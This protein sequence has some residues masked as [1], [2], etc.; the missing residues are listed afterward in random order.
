MAVSLD[1]PAVMKITGISVDRADLDEKLQP[2]G[3]GKLDVE[4]DHVG[5]ERRRRASTASRPVETA[6]TVKSAE[7]NARRNTSRIA[8]SS[9]TTRRTG[10][11]VTGCGEGCAG[12]VGSG[13]ATGAMYHGVAHRLTRVVKRCTRVPSMPHDDPSDVA[14]NFETVSRQDDTPIIVGRSGQF[15]VWARLMLL[16]ETWPKRAD[17]GSKVF[18]TRTRTHPMTS[19]FR[20]LFAAPRRTAKAVRRGER[21]TH[22]PDARSH[23]EAELKTGNWCPRTSSTS[24]GRAKTARCV[25]GRYGLF[26]DYTHSV[27]ATVNYNT[28]WTFNDPSD[29]T[30][31]VDLSVNNVSIGHVSVPAYYPKA[32][33]TVKA[34]YFVG[35]AGNDTFDASNLSVPVSGNAG[36]GDDKMYGGSGNDYFLGGDG[37]DVIYGN[38]GNDVLI[39][40]LGSD[41]IHGNVGNDT[42][43]GGPPAHKAAIRT[44]TTSSATPATTRSTLTPAGP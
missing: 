28:K 18:K 32:N 23:A 44:P 36:V 26:T 29:D 9:S 12:R 27:Q 38:G 35:T 41:V 1:P 39:G 7:E 31:E 33:A 13:T 25:S 22:H 2:R 6:W 30:F 37:N 8:G 17:R 19:L 20:K 24:T 3:V 14:D 10:M 5:P 42:V 16:H 40:E 43:V 4:Q 21:S 11:E 34:V 15:R